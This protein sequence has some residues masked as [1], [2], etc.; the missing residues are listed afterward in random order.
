MKMW[1]KI[2]SLC[3]VLAL[4][5][6]VFQGPV[7]AASAD[8]NSIIAEMIMYYQTYQDEAQTDINRLLE[9]LEEVDSTKAQSWRE[10]MAYWSDI[11]QPGFANEGAVPEGLQTDDSMAIVI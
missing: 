7:A 5:L 2:V 3:T 8:A 4:C 6:S 10:I 1:K 9:D 11:N